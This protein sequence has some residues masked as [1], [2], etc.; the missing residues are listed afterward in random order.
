VGGLITAGLMTTSVHHECSSFGLTAR[1]TVEPALLCIAALSAAYNM[2]TF[3][4]PVCAS[5]QTKLLLRDSMSVGNI[6]YRSSFMTAIQVHS[7][8]RNWVTTLMFAVTFGRS[9]AVGTIDARYQCGRLGFTLLRRRQR[10]ETITCAYHRL[11][12]H[13]AERNRKT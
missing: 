9:G 12:A 11:F 1:R 7:A 2:L 4:S 3:C 10:H 8:P 13:H 5:G 6:E